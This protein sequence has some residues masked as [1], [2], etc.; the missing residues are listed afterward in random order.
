MA[1]PPQS[2]SVVVVGGGLVGLS[3]AML[4]AWNDVPCICTFI[5][6]SP[7]SRRCD[8]QDK[9]VRRN[10]DMGPVLE[11]HSSP[12]LHPRAVGYTPRTMEIFDTVGIADQIPQVEK[13][14]KLR[15]VKV[16]SMAGN[17]HEEPMPWKPDNKG[18]SN[19]T[20]DPPQYT[21]F[22]GAALAQDRLG[23]FDF[24]HVP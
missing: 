21:P 18:V 7:N 14:F 13:S 22:M 12:S 23:M 3:A 20:E 24:N 2:T 10:A 5:Y 17:W 16:E 1:S 6:Y 11:K 4:L 8:A 19:S 15:R 9:Q